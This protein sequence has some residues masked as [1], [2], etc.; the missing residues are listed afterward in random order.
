MAAQPFHESMEFL[1]KDACLGAFVK[2][3]GPIRHRRRH[4]GGAF[5]SL[6]EAIIYQQLTGKA[7]DT[8]LR[9]FVALFPGKL[10]RLGH[11]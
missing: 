8:I 2:S 5:Q 7:A 3:H 11:V 9:R 10:F 4:A 6:A 1:K